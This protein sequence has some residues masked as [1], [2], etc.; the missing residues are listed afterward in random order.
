MAQSLD[1]VTV[2]FHA[3]FGQAQKNTSGKPTTCD[4]SVMVAICRLQRVALL[5][6]FHLRKDQRSHFL[7]EKQQSGAPTKGN[8]FQTTFP[9]AEV[10]FEK[11]IKCLEGRVQ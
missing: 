3:C 11:K 1:A 6:T 2:K 5:G 4:S 10:D 7:L 8:L 9:F